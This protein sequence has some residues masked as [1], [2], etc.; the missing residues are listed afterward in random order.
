MVA[1]SNVINFIESLNLQRDVAS[2]LL[3]SMES[4]HLFLERYHMRNKNPVDDLLDFREYKINNSYISLDEFVKMCYTKGMKETF[5]STFYQSFTSLD[6]EVV[7]NAVSKGMV[8]LESLYTDFKKNP[9]KNI[10]KNVL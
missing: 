7:G 3:E 4:C 5:E 6:I 10:L 9:N 1:N 8:T 2:L